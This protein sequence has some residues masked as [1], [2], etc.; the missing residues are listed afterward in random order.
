VPPKQKATGLVW[1]LLHRWEDY[2]ELTEGEKKHQLARK[3]RWEN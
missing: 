2:L 3:I 1:D